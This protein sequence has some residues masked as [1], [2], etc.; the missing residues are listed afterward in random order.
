MGVLASGVC[1]SDA[2]AAL[3]GLYGGLGPAILDYSG[4]PALS[5]LERIEGNWYIATA[6]AGTVVSRHPLPAPALA[7]CDPALAF[8]DGAQL[9]FAVSIVWIVA[10]SFIAFRRVAR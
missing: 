9:A 5:Y 7:P 2:S 1:Y 3:D 6:Q 4:A 10:W 8:A